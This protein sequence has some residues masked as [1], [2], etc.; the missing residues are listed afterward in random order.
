MLLKAARVDHDKAASL[1]LGL[2]DL[3]VV[4]VCGDSDG[5]RIV[6]VVTAV[7]APAGCPGC[8]VISRSPKAHV[9]T[10]PRDLPCGGAPV[11]LVWCKRRWYC[12]ESSCSRATFTESIP[13]IPA[14]ARLTCRLRRAAGV[15]V[16]D[17]GRTITQSGRDHR[18]SW[19]VVSEAFTQVAAEV[20]PAEPEPLERLG[21]DET[22]RGKRK[23]RLD[24]QAGVWEQI[25]DSWHTG[26]A[27]LDGGQGLLGQVEGRSAQDVISWL[28]Q[29]RQSWL[30]GV[31]VVA[32]DMCA[33]YRSAVRQILPQATLVVD[34][35][36][37]VQLANNT[38]NLVRR[39]V[40]ATLRGRRV[41]KTDPE[42]GIRKRLLRNREDLSYDKFADMWNRLADLGEAG[43]EILAAW[44]AKEKLRDLLGL[45]G[46][47][48]ASSAISAKL[49]A[50]YHWCR[51]SGIG[52][53]E[54]LAATVG[55]W[56]SEVIAAIELDI[57]NAA[58]EGI[59]RLIK[60]E[61]RNAF[62]FR[63]PANQRLRSRCATTRRTR[64]EAK[65]GQLR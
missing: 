38:L 27:D 33:A 16:V 32:I 25:A 54:R 41:R 20:L 58:S 9:R 12:R 50:F 4:E 19:P 13:Q 23:W 28:E 21:I 42:Y 48:P 37:L 61:A 46:T 62:G 43:E 64:R 15:A 8:G 51:H 53:L 31:Q 5:T 24:E 22:R 34:H 11:R 7:G 1:L 55:A 45:A 44:I 18:L 29:R 40:T 47:G 6:T 56:Q 59:N 3:E 30:E 36:H 14:G 63:N 60:L 49:F 26:F 39:R 57:T 52:E 65:S 10:F 17:A 2:G 35:F